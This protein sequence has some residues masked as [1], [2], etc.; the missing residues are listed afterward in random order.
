MAPGRPVSPDEEW[1]TVVARGT[2]AP[3]DT[4]V[5]RYRSQDG[6]SGVD[7]VVP[8]VLDDGTSLIVDRGFVATRDAE[9]NVSSLPA[10]PTGE[11]TVTGWVRLDGT[12]DSTAV[13]D[14]S[15]RSIASGPIGRALGRR[16]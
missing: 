6:E 5:V 11:V 13:T 9:P 3:D 16:V 4:V 15:T 8:L 14:H 7:L 10:P 2:Y 1:R 12:G